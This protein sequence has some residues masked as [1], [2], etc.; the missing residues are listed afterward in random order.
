MR[1]VYN[2]NG[3][4]II[5]VPAHDLDE[6]TIIALAHNAKLTT[7]D[8]TAM[9]TKNGLYTLVHDVSDTDSTQ[10]TDEVMESDE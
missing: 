3:E 6:K 7:D 4:N 2:G 8:Y 9:C 1:L 5:N 10:E